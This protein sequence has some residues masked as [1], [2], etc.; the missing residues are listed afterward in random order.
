M[1]TIIYYDGAC[2]LCSREMAHYRIIDLAGDLEFVDIAAPHFDAG[3][4]G[5]NAKRVNQ[6]MHVRN[7]KG[8]LHTGV[9]ALIEIWKVLPAYQKWVPVASNPFILPILKVG[10]FA[11]ARVR[12]YLPKRT[13]QT[14]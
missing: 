14:F 7:A 10:Y 8:E 12:P 2:H 13:I 11:F 9:A 4:E 3:A 5:L 6:E 1:K